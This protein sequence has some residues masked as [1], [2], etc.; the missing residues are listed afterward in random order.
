MKIQYKCK[1][2]ENIFNKIKNLN[3][4]NDIQ[5]ILSNTTTNYKYQFL[6]TSNFMYN[7]FIKDNKIDKY[8][9]LASDFNLLRIKK[10]KNFFIDGHL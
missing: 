2:T 10:N 4:N 6:R 7:P 9:F 5:I 8:I 1:Y 3:E